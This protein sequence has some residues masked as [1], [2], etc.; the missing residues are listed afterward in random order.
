MVCVQHISNVPVGA[1]DVHEMFNNS[2]ILKVRNHWVNGG[3]E[4]GDVSSM[5]RD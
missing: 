3:D 1:R 5:G 2:L 4:Q